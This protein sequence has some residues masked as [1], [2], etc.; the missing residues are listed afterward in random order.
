MGRDWK[1]MPILKC[2]LRKMAK[3]VSASACQ[4]QIQG[5]SNLFQNGNTKYLCKSLRSPTLLLKKKNQDV[6]KVK[7]KQQQ[8][9]P[10]HQTQH[11]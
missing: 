10:N 2:L 7:Q 3:I 11:F 6:N 5:A 9:N 1:R 4:K 8:Q